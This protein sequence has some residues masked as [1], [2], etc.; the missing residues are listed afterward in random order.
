MHAYYKNRTHYLSYRAAR[1]KKLHIA[2]TKFIY[3]YLLEHPCV[4]CGAKDPRVLQF[5]HVRGRKKYLVSKMVTGRYPM[6]KVVAEIKKCDVRCANCHALRTAEEQRW[7]SNY[8]K[9]ID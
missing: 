2:A 3:E 5:D 8:N 6:Q 7:Y 4:D 1:N 9:R